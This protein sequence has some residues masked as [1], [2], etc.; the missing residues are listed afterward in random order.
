M[1]PKYD[2]C[3]KLRDIR[4]VRRN[5]SIYAQHT[6]VQAVGKRQMCI[7]VE[8]VGNDEGGC[9]QY[10]G[11]TFKTDFECQHR[12]TTKCEKKGSKAGQH[13]SQP[14]SISHLLPHL[15]QSGLQAEGNLMKKHM[16]T[17]AA[18]IDEFLIRLG[19]RSD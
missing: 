11:L 8:V 16:P 10:F 12:R 17:D 15:Y 1:I 18:N 13:F 2:I 6:L 9:A 19:K 7:A 14:R 4:P 3:G 5:A